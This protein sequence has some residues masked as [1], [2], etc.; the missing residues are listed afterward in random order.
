MRI[1]EFN[2]LG[3]VAR[4]I[5]NEFEARGWTLWPLRLSA[6]ETADGWTFK[7]EKNPERQDTFEIIRTFPEDADVETVARSLCEGVADVPFG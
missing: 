5:E 3:D 4:E 1:E 2:D 6:Q 7:L